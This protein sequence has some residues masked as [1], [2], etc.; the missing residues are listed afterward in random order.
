MIIGRLFLIGLIY[1]LGFM[2]VK[3]LFPEPFILLLFQT[4]E[5]SEGNLTLVSLVYM[6]SGLLAGLITAP[7]FGAFLM[8]G[9]ESRQAD[10]SSQTPRFVLSIALTLSMG[11]V[12]GLFIM[13]AYA[14]GLLQ[15]GGVLD[16][17]AV[18]GASNFQPGTP[19]LVLW[20]IARDLLPAGLSGLF[21]APLAGGML[22]KLYTKDAPVQK[23]YDWPE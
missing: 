4:G 1:G 8:R 15:S 6:G 17:L 13:L 20:T 9:R 10:P 16:P 19:L 2:I 7:V 18:I 5:S 21:L 11:V 14:T 23:E 12:S 3:S 22:Q